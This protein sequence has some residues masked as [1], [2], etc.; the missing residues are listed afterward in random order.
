[1]LKPPA[2][3]GGAAAPKFGTAGAVT[4][5]KEA[6]NAGGAAAGAPVK[7]NFFG[8][9]VGPKLKPPGFS[10]GAGPNV[11]TYKQFLTIKYVKRIL[12]VKKVCYWLHDRSLTS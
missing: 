9:S 7:S 12:S 11:N 2:A 8:V 5:P 3:A 1:M 10:A 6:P 4:L